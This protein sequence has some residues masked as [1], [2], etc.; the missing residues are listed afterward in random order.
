M[1]VNLTSMPMAF[2][3]LL[4]K[5]LFPSSSVDNYSFAFLEMN[6]YIGYTIKGLNAYPPSEF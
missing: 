2:S 6:T 5:P 3:D 1:M 4:T